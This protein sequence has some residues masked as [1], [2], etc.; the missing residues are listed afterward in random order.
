MCPP[1]LTPVEPVHA[2]GCC[3]AQHGA[4]TAGGSGSAWRHPAQGCLRARL[5][6]TNHGVR[7]KSMQRKLNIQCPSLLSCHW[8]IFSLLLVHMSIACPVTV[9]LLAATTCSVSNF[10]CFLAY[11]AFTIPVTA[12]SATMHST[13]NNP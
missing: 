10:L 6:Y 5:C 2:Q 11:L 8:S 13:Q 3:A 1:S 7:V 9:A 12:W 4:A